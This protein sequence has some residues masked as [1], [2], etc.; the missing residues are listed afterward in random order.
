MNACNFCPSLLYRVNV[1]PFPPADSEGDRIVISSD[2]E[3]LEALDHFD[4]T[5]F[6]LHIKSE[7]QIYANIMFHHSDTESFALSMQRL[8]S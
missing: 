5:L 3:L 1:H 6:R 4:G 2:E 7:A 8:I